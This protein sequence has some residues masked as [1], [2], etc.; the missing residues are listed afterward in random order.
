MIEGRH[1]LARGQSHQ[2]VAARVEERVAPRQ[3]RRYPLLC[4]GF[5][6]RLDLVIGA[7]SQHMNIDAKGAPGFVYVSFLALER[8]KVRIEENS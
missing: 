2:L 4:D 3:D 6:C 8:W 7:R 1:H 5:K